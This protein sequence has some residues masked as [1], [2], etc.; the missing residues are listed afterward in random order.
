MFEGF[1]KLVAQKQ[2]NWCFCDTQGR[3]R[4]QQHICETITGCPMVL[5]I[6]SHPC[7][8]SS[9][10]IPTEFLPQFCWAH[11]PGSVSQTQPFSCSALC[12]ANTAQLCP[13]LGRGC[14]ASIQQQPK[15]HPVPWGPFSPKQAPACVEL[16]GFCASPS[17]GCFGSQRDACPCAAVCVSLCF[18]QSL[19]PKSFS[20]KAPHQ[21]P[22]NLGR[23]F[24]SLQ[25]YSKQLHRF[26]PQLITLIYKTKKV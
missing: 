22:D 18:L 24:P 6:L 17:L 19:L 20:L 4:T 21:L 1:G 3:P 12:A 2:K 11:T 26:I 5:L 14:E 7:P 25:L 13:H 15:S 8:E 16:T 9:L 23:I 10:P